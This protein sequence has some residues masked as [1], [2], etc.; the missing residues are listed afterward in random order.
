[1][2]LL[3]RGCGDGHA[4]DLVG[5]LEL[6][7]EHLLGDAFRHRLEQGGDTAALGAL[8]ING[9]GGKLAPLLVAEVDGADSS[10]AGSREEADDRLENGANCGQT[11]SEKGRER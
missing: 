9:F 10:F 11:V 7:G 6:F 8:K 2:V 4:L 5:V 1:M 3:R